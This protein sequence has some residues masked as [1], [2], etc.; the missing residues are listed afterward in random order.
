MKTAHPRS[1]WGTNLKEFDA[2]G[3]QTSH[4]FGRLAPGVNHVEESDQAHSVVYAA[5]GEGGGLV[6]QYTLLQNARPLYTG[7]TI[8]HLGQSRYASEPK[9]V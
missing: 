3:L 7:H 8:A 2:L 4:L 6:S 1:V 5:G 9:P